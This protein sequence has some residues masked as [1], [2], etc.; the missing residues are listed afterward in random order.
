MDPIALVPT[1]STLRL[2]PAP[3]RPGEDARVNPESD[4]PP[5]RG[6]DTV[7]FSPLA[8]SAAQNGVGIRQDLVARVRAEIQAGTYDT[9]EK[10]LVALSKALGQVDSQG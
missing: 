3:F 10:Y 4:S 2:D 5:A 9:P 8:R 7:E 1:S 6:G